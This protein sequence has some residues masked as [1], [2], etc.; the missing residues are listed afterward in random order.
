VKYELG[1]Y[2]QEDDILHSHRR[3]NLKS[4]IVNPDLQ[5]RGYRERSSL[6]GFVQQQS[7]Q[8]VPDVVDTSLHG[9][10]FTRSKEKHQ[11]DIWMR[12]VALDDVAIAVMS[13][14][15]C[16]L[17]YTF[18]SWAL[19]Q[20]PTQLVGGIDVPCPDARREQRGQVGHTDS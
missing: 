13:F 2:I 8:N 1:F 16:I 3:E 14:V 6:L 18:P 19:F 10:D 4:Y 7:F 5:M 17:G 20:F 12:I 9:Y 15:H 11:Q